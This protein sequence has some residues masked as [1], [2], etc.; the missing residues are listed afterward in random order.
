[1]EQLLLPS[2]ISFTSGAS[3]REATLVIEPFFHGYGRT[4]GN[5]L[6]RVLLSSLPGAAV[7]AVKIK[8]V[9]HEFTPVPGV[10][11]DALELILNL[12]SLRL[13]CHAE[14]SVK[15]TLKKSGKGEITAADIEP[16]ADV[17]I[18]NP[19]LKIGTLADSSSEIDME[20]TISRGRGFLPTE[21]RQSIGEIGVIAVDAL[22]SP[23]RHVG[24]NVEDTRV[25]EITNYDKL[26]MPIETDGSISPQEAVKQA[27]NI[28]LDHLNLIIGK[29][30]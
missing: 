5:S 30:E 2:S 28:L 26:I 7:T 29:I 9:Q 20:I 12:K 8:G 6:R 11:E 22:F 16:N 15:L 23:V 14:E 25:G 13:R 10:M 19:D 27:I 3:D 18:M 24:I 4:V 1:M 21:E 17:E